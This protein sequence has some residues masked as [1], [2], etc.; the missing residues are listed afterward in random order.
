V[1]TRETPKVQ[2]FYTIPEVAE[3]LGVSPAIVYDLIAAGRIQTR[4]VGTGSKPRLRVA[5]SDFAEY[6]ES[7]KMSAP[8]TGRAA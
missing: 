1:A 2:R 4:D 5:E 7:T 6:Q 3:F 8:K